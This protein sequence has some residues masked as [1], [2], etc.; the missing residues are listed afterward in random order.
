MLLSTLNIKLISTG[1]KTTNTLTDQTTSTHIWKPEVH[2]KASVFPS[3]SPRFRLTS[4]VPLSRTATCLTPCE[5]RAPFPT[6]T[7]SLSRR[8]L[9]KLIFKRDNLLLKTT[10]GS[11]VHVSLFLLLRDFNTRYYLVQWK[12]LH[13]HSSGKD[14]QISHKRDYL[15]KTFSY[16]KQKNE[17]T[18]LPPQQR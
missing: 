12:L 16:S 10:H 13:F 8:D 7:S 5:W 17:K 4:G 18:P 1:L 9:W 6:V 11:G 2:P 3:G 15:K 14:F